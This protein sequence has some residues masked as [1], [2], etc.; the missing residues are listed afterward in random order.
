MKSV[1]LC[2][3]S[4]T[5]CLNTYPH[6]YPIGPYIFVTSFSWILHLCKTDRQLFYSSRSN[7]CF[8]LLV[9]PMGTGANW[10]KI[11][12]ALFHFRPTGRMPKNTQTSWGPNPFRSIFLRSRSKPCPGNL[13]PISRGGDE[14]RRW[15]N[16]PAYQL[17]I[18][19]LQGW[20]LPPIFVTEL[21]NFLLYT[22]K[23]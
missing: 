19:D 18:T 22:F 5:K 13:S 21:N 23:L 7:N 11:F 20:N 14:N 2:A 17:W 6:Y 10:A 16:S 15:P 12:E 1:P 3:R 9:N 8:R 4:P